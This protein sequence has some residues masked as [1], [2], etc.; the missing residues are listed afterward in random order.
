MSRFLNGDLSWSRIELNRGNG[1]LRVCVSLQVVA[2]GF[3]LDNTVG[4]NRGM[5]MV[6][7]A[8]NLIYVTVC[9]ACCEE[10]G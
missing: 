9:N 4:A 10:V 2:S 7:A 3:L 8:V 5:R 6:C 1:Y